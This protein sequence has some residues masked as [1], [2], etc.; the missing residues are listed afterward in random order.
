EEFNTVYPLED[1]IDFLMSMF[2]NLQ[3]N[4]DVI[5]K[6]SVILRNLFD[7]NYIPFDTDEFDSALDD[8]KDNTNQINNPSS[9]EFS[10]LDIENI[11][12]TNSLMEQ[13]AGYI[14]RLL[15]GK[16]TIISMNEKSNHVSNLLKDKLNSELLKLR[17][18][19][20]DLG[21][22]L[23]DKRL[24][25]IVALIDLDE[26]PVQLLDNSANIEDS[27]KEIMNFASIAIDYNDLRNDGKYKYEMVIGH[28]FMP[29]QILK[30]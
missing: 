15:F 21:D 5:H 9:Q 20:I 11:L 29:I 1:K 4:T 30:S 14:L 17:K 13:Q 18:T 23:E 10:R 28:S 2:N 25:A 7:I 3:S 22:I 19:L 26:E 16:F 12:K 8:D 27:A 6:N 24:K